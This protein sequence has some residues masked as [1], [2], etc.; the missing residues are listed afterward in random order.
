M[1]G[2]K[3]RPVKGAVLWV[4]PC[5]QY[6]SFLGTAETFANRWEGKAKIGAD[7]LAS[8]LWEVTQLS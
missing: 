3:H 8:S 6:G 4:I 1:E 5:G 2:E 7:L